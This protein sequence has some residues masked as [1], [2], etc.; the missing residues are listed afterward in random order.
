ML[1]TSTDPRHSKCTSSLKENQMKLPHHVAGVSLAM[2]LAACSGAQTGSTASAILVIG[3]IAGSATRLS[4][5]L[6]IIVTE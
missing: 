2:A 4:V 6:G 3:A 5:P 1:A